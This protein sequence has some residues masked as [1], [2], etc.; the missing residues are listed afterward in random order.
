MFHREV[1]MRKAE[2]FKIVCFKLRDIR[3]LFELQKNVPF[4]A[5]FGSRITHSLSYRSV[6][7]PSVSII[8]IDSSEDVEMELLELVGWKF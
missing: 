8:T 7:V 4:Y 5:G 3:R 1:M 2:A 6:N